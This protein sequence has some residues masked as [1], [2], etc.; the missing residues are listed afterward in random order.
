MGYD[1]VKGDFVDNAWF[2]GGTSFIIVL[3]IL[4]IWLRGLLVLG[5]LYYY[6]RQKK[7][8]V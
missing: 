2:L 6:G 7:V 4:T 5:S 1:Y 8:F 3:N